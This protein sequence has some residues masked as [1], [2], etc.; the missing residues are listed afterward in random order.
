MGQLPIQNM[1]VGEKY[2]TSAKKVGLHPYGWTERVRRVWRGS[3][4]FC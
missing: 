2:V 1:N 3:S 4:V